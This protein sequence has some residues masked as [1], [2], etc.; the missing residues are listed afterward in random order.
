[1]SYTVEKDYKLQERYGTKLYEITLDSPAYNQ[2]INHF[3]AN[4]KVT[5]FKKIARLQA[6]G[7]QIR[8]RLIDEDGIGWQEI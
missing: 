2:P 8:Q 5:D 7:K 3:Y 1:M 6:K 4:C